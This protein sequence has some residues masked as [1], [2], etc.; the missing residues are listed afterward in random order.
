MTEERDIVF[1]GYEQW[2]WTA[3]AALEEKKGR[4]DF[5]LKALGLVYFKYIQD[6]FA[7]RYYELLEEGEGREEEAA[8]YAEA[9]YCFVP[10][11]ARWIRIFSAADEHKGAALDGA[12]EIVGQEGPSLAGLWPRRYAALDAGALTMA[13]ERL[14]Y[15]CMAEPQQRC[16]LDRRCFDYALE[17]FAAGSQKLAGQC[18]TPPG[19]AK[20]AAAALQIDGGCIYDPCCGV[21]NLLLEAAQYAAGNGGKKLFVQGQE[22][23]ADLWKIARMN[24]SIHGLDGDLGA[25]NADTF[26]KCQYPVLKADYILADPPFSEKLRAEV[27][28]AIFCGEMPADNAGF[29]WMLHMLEHLA[30]GGRMGVLLANNYL[31]GIRKGAKAFR[32]RLVEQDLVDVIIRLPSQLYPGTQAMSSLWILSGKKALPG[33]TLFVDAQTIG[34][35][36]SKSLRVLM[37]EDV[38]KIGELCRIFYSGR[39]LHK[40][41]F[42]AVVS[43]ADIAEQDYA[44]HPGCYVE[45]DIEAPMSAGTDD[46]MAQLAGELSALLSRSHSMEMNM[47]R[48][49]EEIGYD[50]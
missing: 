48:M 25:E 15:I 12:I 27:G 45:R 33:M 11:E 1:P 7:L 38:Q 23:E 37:K 10:G 34:T 40:R 44:L 47:R 21:G 22:R 41:G 32:Q 5:A 46:R 2:V 26:V 35:M 29:S 16:E 28:E 20:L 49:L 31:T 19:V 3:L 9:G 13:V 6:R 18:C 50:L 42:C 36:E 24:L 39:T 43:R 14:H 17:R 4:E 8:A 30:P